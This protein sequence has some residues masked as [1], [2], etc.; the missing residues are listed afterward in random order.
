MRKL[1]FCGADITVYKNLLY[2]M[3]VFAKGKLYSWIF[4]TLTGSYN[5]IACSDDSRLKLVEL[6]HPWDDYRWIASG[7]LEN[8]NQRIHQVIFYFF[9]NIILFCWLV[10]ICFWVFSSFWSA[11]LQRFK[12]LLL[13]FCIASSLHL[14]LNCIEEV[15]FVFIKI[16]KFIYGGD[17]KPIF[18]KIFINLND[19]KQQYQTNSIIINFLNF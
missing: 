6:F 14:W 1:I 13:C 4:S 7:L 8:F 15:D 9:P 17:Y 12:I 2:V 5:H 3:M 16:L 11:F 18:W 10:I 19:K